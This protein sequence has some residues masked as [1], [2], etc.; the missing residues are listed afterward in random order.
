MIAG[1]LRHRVDTAFMPGV[2]GSNPAQGKPSAAHQP[3]TFDSR[4][5]ILGTAG[6]KTAMVRQPRAD[7][8]A[9]AF[10]EYQNE[11]AHALQ[12]YASDY[13]VR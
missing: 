4:N 13:P 9:V 7:D 2:A 10:N 3:K 11:C 12:L 5:R 8:H 6:G 1:F